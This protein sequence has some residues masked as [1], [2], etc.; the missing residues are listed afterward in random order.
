MTGRDADREGGERGE[1]GGAPLARGGRLALLGALALV[2]LPA[3]AL[4]GALGN[5]YHLDDAYRI[6]QNPEIERVHPIWRHLVDPRTSTSLPTLVQYRPLLPLTLSLTAWT[7]DRLGVERVVAHRAGNLAVHLLTGLVLWALC[8]ELLRR[9]PPGIARRRGALGF[10]AALLFALHPVATLPVQYLCARDLGLANLLLAAALL[11][12]ARM[13]RRSG[14]SVGG[15]A[16]TLGLLA[17]SLLAKTNG[18]AFFGVVLAFEL[19][20]AGG[21]AGDPRVWARAGAALAVALAFFAWTRFLGFSDAA[22]LVVRDRSW[23]A[24]ALTELKVHVFH[25]LRNAVWPLA[26]R[27]L[28]DVAE[29]GGGDPRALLGGAFVAASLVLAWRA[30]RRRPELAF[31]VLAYWALF[32]PTS[33]VIPLRSFA[34]DYR[35]V[36]SLVFLALCA[37]AGP[38]AALP[39][40]W[41]AAAVAAAAVFLGVVS[42]RANATWRTEL[43]LWR[44]AVALGTTGRGHQSFAR[45]VQATDAVL[46]EEHYQIA[47]RHDPADVFT[48]INL[49]LLRLERGRIVEGMAELERAAQMAPD[50]A[51]VQHRRTGARENAARAS[52]R[53]AELDPRNPEHL[54]WAARDR[55]ALGA[56]ADA[57]PF[58][59]ALAAGWGEHEDSLFLEAWSRQETGRPDRAIPLY[60]RFLDSRPENDQAWYSLGLAHRS[61]G[62]PAD[63]ARCMEEALRLAPG[64]HDCHFYLAE[65]YERVGRPDLAA[66]HREAYAAALRARGR[67]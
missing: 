59:E 46:A 53:A 2:L 4:W 45:A 40:R 30:R 20:L 67:R 28:P 57:L 33:S 56:H 37:A 21:R 58:L 1:Q 17:L 26:L 6:A 48:R 27:P 60:E 55:Q 66:H 51:I 29:S 36:P 5:A 18:A 31:A 63:A 49:G 42:H 64:R 62:A 54:L 43:S 15:W 38:L 24:Y 50:R 22:M 3:A 35:Q 9:A 41:A 14:D 25:Y 7:G 32:A 10:A 61:R 52:A 12:Y 8:A 19:T 44:E 47:L 11:A 23:V 39:A 65:S 16:A 34:A 13:R